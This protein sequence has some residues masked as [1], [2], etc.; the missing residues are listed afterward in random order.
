[1]SDAGIPPPH[2]GV[3][4]PPFAIGMPADAF[5][6]ALVQ[7]LP[8]IAQMQFLS[9]PVVPD[10]AARV[11]AHEAPIDLETTAREALVHVES[12]RRWF[13]LKR[14]EVNADVLGRLRTAMPPGDALGVCS[15]VTL[16]DGRIMHIPMMDFKAFVSTLNERSL[17][18][19]FRQELGEQ[20]GAL[21]DSGNSYHYYGCRLV[22]VTDWH[23]FLGKCLLTAPLVDT[24]YIGHR[25]I[26]GFCILRISA[27]RG[28]PRVPAMLKWW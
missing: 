25:L 19:L 27:A 18:R 2:D 5:V 3:K 17:L 12:G 1:M 23:A 14:D 24:R 4:E 9:Y 22:D 10:F 16:Y 11:F 21:L 8:D 26:E 20:S 6:I 13:P 28:K 15:K 7:M